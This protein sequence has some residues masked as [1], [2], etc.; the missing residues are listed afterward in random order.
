MT[1]QWYALRS[2]P[3]KEVALWRE[4][5]ARGVEVFYPQMRVQPKNP[6]ARKIRPYFPGYLFVQLDLHQSGYSTFAW[7]PHSRGLVSF[8]AEPVAVPDGL[9]QDIR[10]WVDEINGAGG[11]QLPGL[12]PG[13]A[14]VIQDGPFA[15]QEAIFDTR[16]SGNE[17][18][19]VLLKLLHG[20]QMPLELPSGQ[21]E[22]KK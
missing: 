15:G 17:R 1:L 13:E 3:N 6:R 12:K 2:K 4:V 7:M 14:V 10:R 8:G 19:R 11:E 20:R 16:I 22:R 9:I 21:V 5:V 18:V